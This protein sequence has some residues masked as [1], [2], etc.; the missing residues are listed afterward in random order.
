MVAPLDLFYLFVENVFGN[1]LFAVIG[2][3]TLLALMCMSGR[4]SLMLTFTIV[5]LFLASML[6]GFF[7]SIIAI[8][9]F[10]MTFIYFTW[11]FAALFKGGM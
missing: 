1:F 10:A 11:N 6:I 5:S 9:F 8:M 2:L 4:M 3:A 7:G